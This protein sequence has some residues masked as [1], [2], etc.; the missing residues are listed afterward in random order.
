MFT[1]L[2]I[3]LLS[4]PVSILTFV[5]RIIISLYSFTIFLLA[6]LLNLLVAL[7]MAVIQLILTVF[8]GLGRLI[9]LLASSLISHLV[10]LYDQI[11][12]YT[13]KFFSFLYRILIANKLLLRLTLFIVIVWSFIYLFNFFQTI[14]NPK[15]IK[16]FD[17]PGALLIYDKHAILLYRA[18][19][20]IYSFPVKLNEI[21][22]ILKEATLTA[23]GGGF[24][25]QRL[26]NILAKQLAKN[27]LSKNENNLTRPIKEAVIAFKIQTNFSQDQILELYLNTLS[28]G[29]GVIGI[30]AA[31]QRYFRKN[32]TEL[33]AKEA[34]FLAALPGASSKDKALIKKRISF[35]LDKLQ[36]SNRISSQQRKTIDQ[37]KLEFQPTIAYKRA[38]H[39]VDYVLTFLNNR[40]GTN[41][42]KKGMIVHTTVDLHLQN[43]LQQQL[44]DFI[45]KNKQNNATNAGVIVIDSQDGSILSMIGS[46]NYFD[47]VN[48]QQ[49][50][51]VAY[52]QVLKEAHI[53][54]DI[55]D[56]QGKKIYVGPKH[57]YSTDSH[58]TDPNLFG[59]DE[60]FSRRL[61]IAVWAGSDNGVSITNDYGQVNNLHAES[62]YRKEG[63]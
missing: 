13:L 41:L 27:T 36:S 38:P 63:D 52:R 55:Y 33:T 23:T 37:Q 12:K 53:V 15:K 50:L 45:A 1:K 44:I 26:V 59:L 19:K 16:D 21:P 42:Y 14:P 61:I 57:V 24:Y 9:L 51:L 6:N 29:E 34:V 35:I 7:V 32:V 31:S 2:I 46:A 47:E 54:K 56:L 48:G 62:K 30:Q 3:V 40:Y 60:A 17:Q 10:Y 58:L 20:N 22:P 39:A 43:Y 25:N 49:N 4:I 11:K 18:Y 8:A 28:Y 5:G